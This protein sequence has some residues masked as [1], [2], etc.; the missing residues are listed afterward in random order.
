MGNVLDWG[1]LGSRYGD[2]RNM[3]ACHQS[4]SSPLHINEVCLTTADNLLAVNVCVYF[5]SPHP[6]EATVKDMLK[7]LQDKNIDVKQLEI[8]SGNHCQKV[9]SSTK[10]GSSSQRHW[11]RKW[12]APFSDFKQSGP[13][14]VHLVCSTL[15]ENLEI[16]CNALKHTHSIYFSSF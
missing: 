7:E 15:F 5:R 6:E 9:E 3:T 16:V 11:F 12:E 4:Q 8:S 2:G 1:N 14:N 10:R 13:M